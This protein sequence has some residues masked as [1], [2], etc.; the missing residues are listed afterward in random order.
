[1]VVSEATTTPKASRGKRKAGKTPESNSKE[2]KMSKK[3][4]KMVS[5]S[6]GL[7]GG[8]GRQMALSEMFG[9][10]SV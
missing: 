10:T 7:G 9:R 4:G 8:G 3:N 5:S 2:R 6:N 1:M